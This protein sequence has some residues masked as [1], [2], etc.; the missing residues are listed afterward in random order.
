MAFAE[1]AGDPRIAPRCPQPTPTTDLHTGTPLPDACQ[2][3]LGLGL[4]GPV[5]MLGDRVR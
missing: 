5:S 3:G 2:T 4:A 1:S